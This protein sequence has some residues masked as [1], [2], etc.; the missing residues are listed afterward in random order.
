MT[1]DQNRAVGGGMIGAPLESR[2]RE[3]EET[4]DVLGLVR[5]ALRGRWL[6]AM[7]LGLLLAPVAGFAAWKWTRPV[8][9]SEGLIRID[10]TR[11]G[12]IQDKEEAVPLEVWEAFVE[13]QAAMIGSRDMVEQALE[14]DVWKATGLGHSP[15]VIGGF[16]VR[17][18]VDSRPNKGLVKI[19][20]VHTDPK[21]AAAAVRAIIDAYALAYHQQSEQFEQQRIGLLEEQRTKL[22]KEMASIEAAMRKITAESGEANVDRLFEARAAQFARL[23]ET[24]NA[25]RLAQILKQGQAGDEKGRVAPKESELL[26]TA[27]QLAA[28]DPTM[29]SYLAEREKWEDVIGQMQ[30]RGV[31]E[32]HPDMVRARAALQQAEARVQ[33]YLNDVRR[34]PAVMMPGPGGAAGGGGAE[35]SLMTLMGQ[36][37]EALKLHEAAIG[38]IYEQ[39]RGEMLTLE[40]RRQELAGLRAR[41]KNVGEELARV[42]DRLRLLRLESSAAGRMS[43]IQKGDVPLSPFKDRRLPLAGMGFLGGAG[44]PLALFLLIGLIKTRYQYSEEAEADLAGRMPL[45][46]I[47]PLLP[48]RMHDADRALDAAQCVHQI[49]VMLQVGMGPERRPAYLLSSAS[50]GEG[51]TSLTAALGLSFAASGSRTLLIDCDL[52]GQKLSHGFEAEAM[53]GLHEALVGG[54]LLEHVRRTT[55]ENLWIL[56]V[57]QGGVLY[58]NTL[59]AAAVQRLLDEARQ[60]FD[61]VLID[62]GPILGSVEA[63]TVA[64]RVDGVI[65]TIA[66]QQQRPMV[67][68][69]V[70]HL[71][72]IGAKVTGTVFNRATAA[73]L[74]RSSNSLSVRSASSERA[75][76]RVWAAG[77]NEASELGPLVRSVASLLPSSNGQDGQS[78]S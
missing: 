63:S 33:K 27:E 20:F 65:L 47:L 24:L 70:R 46:G 53:S 76:A 41:E 49:R 59:S 43:V 14:Q 11:P 16:A 73:D 10:Y 32:G 31:L 4:L 8:Y 3:S 66:R 34:R 78:M 75:I 57:G 18:S 30:A 29:R 45:L 56:P 61:V 77:M 39:A 36:S 67:E 19:S 48:E 25:I 58:A 22:E 50:P 69:A 62:S 40:S 28:V 44:L 51:K 9:R 60:H 2:G 12:V 54:S 64:T 35:L 6:R 23:Q 7:V 15:I 17:L 26:L 1:M 13:S 72:A 38:K 42:E 37:L 74:G 71:Q 21:I 52:V 5:R 55:R 68:R